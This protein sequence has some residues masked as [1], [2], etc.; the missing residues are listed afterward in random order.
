MLV[1]AWRRAESNWERRD[2]FWQGEGCRIGR[3]E[4]VVLFLGRQKGEF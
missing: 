2:A 1:S 4:A 3:R